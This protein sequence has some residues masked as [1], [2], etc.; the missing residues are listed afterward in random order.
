MHYLIE[1]QQQAFS[2]QREN[3]W[4]EACLVW[5]D[6]VKDCPD[7]EHGSGFHNLANCYWE[8]DQLSQARTAFVQALSYEP[9]NPIYLAN[10]AAFL[11]LHGSAEEAYKAH[12]AAL[13][14]VRGTPMAEHPLSALQEIGRCLNYS[15]QKIAHDI[16]T[17]CSES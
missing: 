15:E 3:K 13:H 6:I 10:F 8:T 16:Q 7:W 9:Q 17:F 4:F 11:Q 14:S 12:L 2:L 5:Q 1:K